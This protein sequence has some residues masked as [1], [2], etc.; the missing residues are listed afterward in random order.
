MYWLIL[1]LS[2][3]L[4]SVWAVSLSRSEGFTRLVPS[5]VFLVSAILSIVGLG[6]ALREIPVGTGYA[7]WV[8]IGAALTVAYSMVSG[9]ESATPIKVA[10]I[11]GIVGCVIGL[12]LVSESH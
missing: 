11:L 1:F 4:E 6:Y 12:Q 9:A 7:V 5:L 2:G 10:L 8:G 3:A